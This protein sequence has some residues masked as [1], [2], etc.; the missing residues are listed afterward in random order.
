MQVLSEIHRGSSLS[1]WREQRIG[2]RLFRATLHLHGKRYEATEKSEK[3][4]KYF[5]ALKVL[6]DCVR[7]GHFRV[8]ADD[9]KPAVLVNGMDQLGHGT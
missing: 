8:A 5:L 4:A 3:D 7:L 1:M 6:D 2:K 9:E